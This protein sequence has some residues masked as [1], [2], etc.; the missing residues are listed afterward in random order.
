MTAV[1]N[2]PEYRSRCIYC[3]EPQPVCRLSCCGEVHFQLEPECPS[4]GD[5]VDSLRLDYQ[6]IE[7]Y[8]WQCR[9]CDWQSDP[10]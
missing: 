3:G 9:S 5:D 4:C 8:V 1:I 7:T 2:R 6:G 10:E